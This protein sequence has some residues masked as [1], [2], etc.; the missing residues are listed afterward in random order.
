LFS[1][2][3]SEYVEIP[4][5]AEIANQRDSLNFQKLFYE[6]FVMVLKFKIFNFILFNLKELAIT[7]TE[8]K[9]IAAA[10]NIGDNKTPKIG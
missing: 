10:A 9:L 5:S 8:E 4:L 2:S 6:I 3:W 7:E 1:K